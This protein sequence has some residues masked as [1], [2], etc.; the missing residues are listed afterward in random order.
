MRLISVLI[1]CATLNFDKVCSVNVIDMPIQHLTPFQY[2]QCDSDDRDEDSLC[3]ASTLAQK[4]KLQNAPVQCASSAAKELNDN[5]E[6][7]NNEHSGFI[8]K[9]SELADKYWNGSKSL[10]KNKRFKSESNRS[11]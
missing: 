2:V 9:F 7:S 6:E 8:N 5:E 3:D 4:V 10:L 11:F 1:T